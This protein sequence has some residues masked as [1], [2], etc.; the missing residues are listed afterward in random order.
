V[1]DLDD[2]ELALYGT[3]HTV[4]DRMARR[5]RELT[6]E[7]DTAQADAD[8]LRGYLEVQQEESSELRSS[9]GKAQ[10]ERWQLRD[11]LDSF[12][13]TMK[14]LEAWAVEIEAKR[15]QPGDVEHFIA[16]EL[17]KRMKG[18]SNG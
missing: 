9:I 6:A 15:A 13:A 10:A 17:R 18:D 5:I 7:R 3:G 11:E 12:R 1:A 14:Q 2:T 16:A 8:R 4:A